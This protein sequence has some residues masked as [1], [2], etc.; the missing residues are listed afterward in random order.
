MPR[1]ALSDD[2]VADLISLQRPVQKEVK[3]A[4]QM[5]RGLTVPQLHA[6]K[7]MHLEKLERANDRRIRTIRITK[8]YRGVLLAPDDGS[9]LFT[10][11]RVAPHDEAINW[12]RKRA[13]SVN[14]A[15]GGL[16]VRNVEALEQMET[17]FENKA[18]ATP[19]GS[20]S[21]TRTPCCAISASTTRC[22]VWP[23]SASPR[24]I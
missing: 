22:C 13:Y 7:G 1:L 10:L 16:E 5:F 3:D 23:G 2:F 12:A 6:S 21:S 19:P 8:F 20:S 4:I 18:V 14:G 24:R 11:L 9:E 15:T 17:Y